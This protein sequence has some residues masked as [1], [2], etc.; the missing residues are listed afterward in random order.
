MPY[1]L[2]LDLGIASIGWALIQVQ[3][4]DKD[5]K[6][7]ESLC[8]LLDCGVRIF[9][10]A[11]V[12]KSGASLA[13]ER[14]QKRGQRRIIRRR[15][16]RVA[17]LKYELKKAGFLH[18]GDFI[19]SALKIIKPAP[20]TWLNQETGEIITQQSMEGDDKKFLPIGIWGWRVLALDQKIPDR[21]LALVL[22]H[23]VKHRGY[24]STRKKMDLENLKNSGEPNKEKKERKV[25][26]GV[27][28]NDQLLAQS[29]AENNPSYRTPA[30][31]AVKKFG[32]ETGH[33]HNK[34]N[35][36]SHTFNRERIEEELIEI[37]HIQQR[38]GN[39]KVTDD[40]IDTV[41]NL[42]K[43]QRA[44]LSGDA[45][46]KM[47]GK[48]TFEKDEYRA[49]KHT[50]SAERFTWLSRLN[51]LAIKS[52]NFLDRWPT[53]EEKEILKELPYEQSKLIYA[54]VRK[55]WHLT[56]NQRFNISYTVPFKRKKG[57]KKT[58]VDQKVEK[59]DK[60]V[61]WQ[62]IE[63]RT[64]FE[65]VAFHTIK[66]A[67]QKEGKEDK[68]LILKG[69]R[70]LLDTIG[71]AFSLYKSDE[72][73]ENYLYEKVETRDKNLLDAIFPSLL[74]HISF[75]GT[76]HLSLKALDKILPY[77]E[78]G[79]R[80]D[81]TCEKVYG[82]HSIFAK[83]T[84][85][86]LPP[87]PAGTIRNPVVL[88]SLSQMRKVVN[89][90]IRTYGSP[91]KVHIECTRD[92]GKSHIQRTQEEER[93][94][95][96]REFNEKASKKFK[97][98]FPDHPPKPREV[99][100]Y[101]L[102]EEQQGKSLY[103]GQEIDVR[104]L[105]EPNYIEIDHV[106]PLSRTWDDSYFNK[107]LVLKKENQNKGNQTPYEWL[108]G[109][110]YS[111]EWQEFQGRVQS[112]YATIPA[113]QGYILHKDLPGNPNAAEPETEKVE[114]FLNRNRSDTRYITR[115]A[116]QFIENNLQFRDSEIKKKVFT[117]SGRI[118][119]IMRERW[120]LKK[121]RGNH[122]HHALDAVV[123]ACT[124]QGMEQKITRFFQQ[125]ETGKKESLGFP[126]P[127][128]FFREEIKA[129]IF[130]ST[131]KAELQ[132]KAWDRLPYV[133]HIEQEDYDAQ[134]ALF[135][136][137]MPE[138]KGTGEGHEEILRSPKF[139]KEGKSAAKKPLTK[140]TKGDIGN[141]VGYQA[142]KK[143]REPAFYED[144]QKRLDQFGGKAKT[145]FETDFYK[146]N[147]EGRQGA[148][149]KSVR[150]FSTKTGILLGPDKTK[151]E[152]IVER[153]SMAR[154]DIF[155]KVAH[156]G[157]RA[158]QKNYYAVPVYTYQVATGVLPD[159]TVPDDLSVVDLQFEF[160][161]Y[162]NDL[163]YFKSKSIDAGFYYYRYYNRNTGAIDLQTPDFSSGDK[164]VK[165]KKATE[166]KS[167][168]LFQG[169]GIK[170]A[171]IFEKYTVDVLGRNKRKVHERKRPGVIVKK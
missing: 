7:E 101:R 102:Y 128:D 24:F 116:A 13:A 120:C 155:S 16:H 156:K 86:L 144:L 71:V 37:L 50:Y 23:L 31:L 143:G 124:T 58:A 94:L 49:P 105:L 146:P 131:P 140:L 81:E 9:K 123:V 79:I 122:R 96:N 27:T 142:G 135:V 91:Y 109:K 10:K 43:S 21:F 48:C 5:K 152:A 88:R 150:V 77:L 78:E 157:K 147:R 46:K 11:E 4:K 163:V 38:L 166:K 162:P 164:S 44:A 62:K 100:K 139:L 154:I 161:L 45:L 89:A 110:E 168:G 63:E 42:L 80:Y 55:K 56:E 111:Q 1:I 125:K 3:P 126:E 95:Q 153:S 66:K 83:N 26:K 85:K 54:Q 87:V 36:Y 149:V 115:Q 151:P 84:Q 2:G 76:I 82:S 117:P 118:T 137:R 93:Q 97:E 60:T 127:W 107:V 68:W 22:L 64:F 104:R 14:R 134:Y 67:L 119:K 47:W 30:E 129:R 132:A 35:D 19:D 159:K 28:E 141:I 170:Q 136:S 29:L 171:E 114:Q 92:L 18:D 138:H 51:N 106:L 75:S 74:K 8:A 34:K 121:D 145:V 59:K 98:L 25:L 160:A 169:V 99:L 73:I 6:T 15:A 103:S 108:K 158:G 17:R 61:A 165:K 113:K 90:I 41:K 72:D 20:M 130:S 167:F 112:L 52:G 57:K 32:K 33:I 65:P 148:L 133:P 53:L 12:P 39:D 69:N 40:V 70:S